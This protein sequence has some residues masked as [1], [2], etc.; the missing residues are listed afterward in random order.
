LAFGCDSF[1]PL[2]GSLGVGDDSPTA[3]AVG[4]DLPPVN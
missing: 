2:R 1:R 3:C 4:Y